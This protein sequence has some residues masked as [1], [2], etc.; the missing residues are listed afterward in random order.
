M[1]LVL[2]VSFGN[3]VRSRREGMQELGADWGKV[4]AFVFHNIFDW[5][6]K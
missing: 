5:H 6:T 3:G 4:A 2:R 1:E